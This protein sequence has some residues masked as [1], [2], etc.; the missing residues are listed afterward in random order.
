M[1]DLKLYNDLNKKIKGKILDILP[2]IFNNYNLYYDYAIKSFEFSDELILVDFT[3]IRKGYSTSNY[4]RFKISYLNMSN[5]DILLDLQE[6][7]K[8]LKLKEEELKEIEYKKDL[9][10]FNELKNKLN[11]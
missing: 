4:I 5:D 2:L 10:L 9:H 11:L 7:E 8:K 3:Y 1:I 6:E